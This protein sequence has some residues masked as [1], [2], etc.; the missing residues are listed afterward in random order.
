MPESE[1]YAE[2]IKQALSA[3]KSLKAQLVAEQKKLHEP[4]AIVGMAMRLPGG[5][6]N[7][8]QLLKVLLDNTDTIED[9]PEN[10]FDAKALYD[11]HGGEGKIILKQ[12]GYLQNIDQFDA[13]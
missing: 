3:I 2:Q 4:I 8:Q 6:E 11:E 9:I 10:R 13:S 7:E 1:K 5:I 12:G